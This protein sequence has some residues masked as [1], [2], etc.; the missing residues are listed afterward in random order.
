V[1]RHI[2]LGT[3]YIVRVDDLV[4]HYKVFQGISLTKPRFVLTHIIR[5]TEIPALLSS[6]LTNTFDV[7]ATKKNCLS[8]HFR[9]NVT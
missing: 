7:V 1:I 4:S 2:K 5:Q 8:L 6:R 3:V 9:K